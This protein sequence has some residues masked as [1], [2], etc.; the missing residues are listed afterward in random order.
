MA[1]DFHEMDSRVVE[2]P[3]ILDLGVLLAEN[4]GIVLGGALVGAILAFLLALVLPRTYESTSLLKFTEADAAVMKSADVL[5]PVI[6]ELNLLRDDPPD[7]A[8]EKLRK[9]ILPAFRKKD[10]VLQVSTQAKT[11]EAA[12][13]L[14]L[15]VLDAFRQFTLPKG[16]SLEA[17]QA[18]IRITGGTLEELRAAIQRVGK[19]LDKVTPGTEA[20]AMT[21]SYVLMVEQRDAREKQLFDLN[22]ALKKSGP[23]VVLQA[24][25]LPTTPL[26]PRKALFALVG[27][28]LFGLAALAFVFIRWGLASASS[29]P[30]QYEK[31]RRI[32][33]ALSFKLQ[34]H[35]SSPR[36]G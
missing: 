23:E 2:E 32:Q 16:R 29:S 27:A 34:R 1:D 6:A 31:I 7:L 28:V 3:S 10:A 12:Q 25:T 15:K 5:M 20:E 26:K 36:L 22:A 21:R 30:P 18:Q 17:V 11:P 19:N 13:L 9:K 35:R 8:I 33:S 4:A 14:N 24:A